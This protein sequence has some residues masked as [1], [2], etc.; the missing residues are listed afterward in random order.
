MQRPLGVALFL[1][2][3]YIAAAGVVVAALVVAW[4]AGL[5][6]FAATLPGRVADPDTTTDAIVVLTG[7]SERLTAGLELLKHRRAR[8]LFVS[9][10]YRGVEVAEL[11]RLS[12]QA[13]S[14]LECCIVLG[15]AADNTQGNA[16]ETA[17]WMAKERFESLRLVTGSYHMRRSLLEFALAM[18]N[19]KV[20]PH[21]VFP[22]AVKQDEWWLWPGTAHLIATEYMKY[23]VAFGRNW[24]GFTGRPS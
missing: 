19:I 1:R 4:L 20:V 17:A 8:K 18:P 13:P 22:E 11:L 6:W 9:G 24:F 2:N 12:R 5:I 15:Y 16:S 14:E 3:R 21:P 23:L 10:V 7:G